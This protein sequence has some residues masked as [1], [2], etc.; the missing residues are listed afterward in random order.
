MFHLYIA[1]AQCAIQETSHDS[2][3]RSAT[4]NNYWHDEPSRHDSQEVRYGWRLIILPSPGKVANTIVKR[5][6]EVL[7]LTCIAE[8]FDDGTA[9]T[10]I[11]SDLKE[12]Q[13]FKLT[14]HLPIMP[15]NRYFN[16]SHAISIF[17]ITTL[18]SPYL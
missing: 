10:N 16:L 1:F 17:A 5:I 18:E 12:D 2:L 14:W 6:D 15:Q 9:N 11:S 13:L 3:D 8:Y 7:N 4:N